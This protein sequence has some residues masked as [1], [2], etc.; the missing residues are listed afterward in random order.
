LIRN[1][2]WLCPALIVV[3]LACASASAAAAPG[4]QGCDPLDPAVCLQPWPNDFFTV[5]DASTD[6]GRR[7]DLNPLATPRNIA[8]N[9]IRPDEWNRSDGFS[10]GQKIVTKVPDLDTP[11]A[12]QRTGA[13]PITDVERTYEPDQ[14]IVVLNADTGRRHLIWAE[15]DANPADPAD[16]NLIIRPA[17]NLDEGGHYI[18]ALR[19]LKKANGKAIKAQH[20]FRVYRDRLKSTDAAVEARRPHMEQVFAILQRAGIARKSLYLTW[21]FTVASER[22]LSER[23]L[24]IRDDAFAALGDTDLTDMQVQGSAPQFTV[25]QTT[26]Y[27]PAQDDKIARKVDGSFV[28]PCYLNAAGCPPGARF[29]YLPGSSVPQ[30]IPGNTMVANFTCLIPRVAVD[31]PAVLPARPSLYGHGLL[32]SASEITAGNI[33]SMANEHNF[34][35][36]ATDWSGMSTQD[37]PNIGTILGDLSNFSSLPDRAQQ[38]F[39]NFMY[40]GRLMIHPA[41]FNTNAAFQ[42]TKDGQPHAVIDPAR[43]F[44]DGN[45]QGGIMGGSLAALAPDFNRAVLGVPAM[46]YSILLRRS[47]D[48]DQY[49]VVLYENYPNELE[50]P[51]ILSLIQNLWDRGEANGYAHHMTGNPYP[52]TPAHEVLL[53]EAFGDHQVANVATEVEARTIGAALRT[54][55]LDPGRHSDVNPY[56]GIPPIASFPYDGSALVVWDS[57]SPTPPPNNTPPRAGADP[58]SHPRSTAIARAMKSEFLK[59]DGAVVDTCGIGACY[60]N[61][62]TGP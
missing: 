29:S 7:L 25:T 59:V 51:L 48:F 56:Y 55:A 5:A 28:V 38:G 6:T 31:G 9:P 8:G 40:L 32:G 11:A 47:V 16:V 53:H 43:L 17:V 37:V 42:F 33:K 35:F 4:E 62:Y 23:A 44:Y 3:A 12:F 10:P 54:P 61:G 21:D 58:H 41:G 50:R 13:V 24:S 2:L 52:N 36:C 39:V 15:M 30:R 49:A 18:V 46:N 34:V 20:P 45:S 26:N 60:A 27:T 1:R 14:P 22:N 57:G 19:N